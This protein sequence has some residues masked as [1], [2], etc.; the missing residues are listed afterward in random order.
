MATS[1]SSPDAA[2]AEERRRWNDDAWLATWLEREPLT[3]PV[4]PMLLDALALQPGERVVDI[5]SGGGGGT[6]EFAVPSG[7]REA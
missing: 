2:N 5:G 1:P 4:T 3:A 7:R 6:I